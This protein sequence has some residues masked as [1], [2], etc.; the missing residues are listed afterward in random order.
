LLVVHLLL[1]YRDLRDVQYYADDPLVRRLL[2][3]RRLPEVSTLSRTLAKMDSRA[4]TEVAAL[5]RQLVGTRLAAEGL[6]RVT[7][8]F[9]GSVRTAGR[10]AEGSAVGFNPRRKGARSYYPLFATVA[11]T[12]Q[13]FDAFWRPGNVHDSHG[14][15]D[16]VIDCFHRLKAFCPTAQ[17]E[18][19]F[20][21][22][23][24]TK[25]LVDVLE[26]L[27]ISF[28][29]SVPFARLPALKA[30]IEQ[31][32]RWNRINAEWSYFEVQWAPKTW[33]RRFRIIC[34]R[35]QV[36]ERRK[37]PVQLD[38]FE[39]GAPG[40]RFTALVTN[41]RGGA[42]AIAEFHH[43]RGSQEKLFGELKDQLAMGH[44]PVRTEAGNQIYMWSSLLAQNLARELQMQARPRTRTT[45]AARQALWVFQEARTLRA[46]LFQR[47]GRLIRPGGRLTLSLAANPAVR[48]Q[49]LELLHPTH[50]PIRLAA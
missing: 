37:G 17:V 45:G 31:R 50:S 5:S 40:Y 30:R 34:L 22:A 2:R 13:V 28:T 41:K 36:E 42:R 10:L 11:Q 4:V 8:D 24:Y 29:I 26:S 16:F 18:A 47:A 33:G 27:E 3:L 32:R 12:A 21:S 1:G 23:F 44:V 35:Q 9:D 19:R 14:A 43:G 25:P 6:R 46:R 20:D 38:L 49:L 39:P 15:D 48:N 7:L